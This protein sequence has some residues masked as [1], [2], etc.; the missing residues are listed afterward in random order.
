MTASTSLAS[1]QTTITP[2]HKSDSQTST[3]KAAAKDQTSDKAASASLPA[4]AAA[5]AA[6]KEQANGAKSNAANGASAS[7]ASSNGASAAKSSDGKA[8]NVANG[9]RPAANGKTEEAKPVST[10]GDRIPASV[11][12]KPVLNGNANGSNGQSTNKQQNGAKP[13]PNGVHNNTNNNINNGNNARVS[14]KTRMALVPALPKAQQSCQR[15]SW[16]ER[17]GWTQEGCSTAFAQCRRLPGPGN[18]SGSAAPSV[19]A[20]TNV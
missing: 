11:P 14:N 13:Q 4:S 1:A 15:S 5:P 6:K 3:D 18:K 12:S 16:S 20:A 10:Q 7:K 8:D 19:A 9:K 17:P 2:S